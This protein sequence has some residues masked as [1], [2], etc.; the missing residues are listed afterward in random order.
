MPESAHDVV[1]V[2]TRFYRD[3][4]WYEVSRVGSLFVTH[5]VANAERAA[6]LFH[7]LSAYLAPQ[8]DVVLIDARARAGWTGYLRAIPAI[9]EALG[10]LRWL[11]A[12]A[13]GVE[14]TLVTA[15]DQISLM[16]TLDLVVI[17]R[18]DAWPGRLEREGLTQR[19]RGS[20]NDTSAPPSLLA[21]RPELTAALTMFAQR[22][23]LDPTV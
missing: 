19:A 11:L 1:A 10:P 3:T 5:V 21:P 4:E 2:G 9:R 6:D 12:S 23:A 7:R 14:F 8:V 20:R 13:G 16:P 18:G 22:L 17:S 15:D